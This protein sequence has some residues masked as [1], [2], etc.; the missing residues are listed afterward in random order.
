MSTTT[1]MT[2]DD[3]CTPEPDWEAVAVYCDW[4]IDNDRYAEA[5][6]LLWLRGHGKWP[7]TDNVYG[8]GYGEPDGSAVRWVIGRTV[9]ERWERAVIREEFRTE[10]MVALG[11][12]GCLRFQ[13]SAFTVTHGAAPVPADNPLH[14]ALVWFIKRYQEVEYL[15]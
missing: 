7:H 14:D 8:V 3:I 13:S 4:L 12:I 11:Y 10:E 6:A 15:L 9:D 1:V 5:R 2:L